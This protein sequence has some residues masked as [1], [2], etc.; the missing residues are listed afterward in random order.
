MN[1]LSDIKIDQNHVLF[2]KMKLTRLGIENTFQPVICFGA[3]PSR[4]SKHRLLNNNS[5]PVSFRFDRFIMFSAST[6]PT[7]FT[8]VQKTGCSF[9]SHDGSKRCKIVKN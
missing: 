8:F 7:G 6:L 9:C 3:R 2:F 1:D 5:K 4:L